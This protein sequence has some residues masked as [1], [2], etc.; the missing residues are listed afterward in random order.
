M[1]YP[2]FR[3]LAGPNGSGKTHLFNHLKSK[4]IIH[5]EIYVNADKIEKELKQNKSFNFNAYRVKV[6]DK[7]FKKFI[8]ISG[9]F[10]A[11]VKNKTFINKIFIA[12]GKL[13]FKIPANQ[14]NSYHASFVASYLTEKLIETKQS[15]CFETVMSHESKIELLKLA[16]Q[17]GY[18][19]YLYFVFTDNIEV[20]VA[21]VKLRHLQGFHD[22][23]SDVIRNRMSRTFTLMPVAFNIADEAYLI[24]NSESMSVIVEKK[25]NKVIKSNNIPAVISSYVKNIN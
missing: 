22:V 19:T 17:S 25:N 24:D 14:I 15:F 7:E 11:K 21:R 6:S 8:L 4:G 1:G 3:L 2:R 10:K 16:K 5:T 13:R 18:K 23:D 12:G 20:N 9:L